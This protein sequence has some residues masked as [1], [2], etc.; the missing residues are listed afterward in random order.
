MNEIKSEYLEICPIDK[1]RAEIEEILEYKECKKDYYFLKNPFDI[2]L[3]SGECEKL[4]ESKKLCEVENKLK[5]FE[6]FFKEI[7]G[8]SPFSL[9]RYWAKRVLKGESFSIIA[10]TGFGKSTFGITFSLF[11][12]EVLKIKRVYYI[13]PTKILL[14]EIEDKFLR[15]SKNLKEV[16]ILLLKN[17]KIKKN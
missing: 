8:F 1:N 14:R 9:Q 6:L 4:K 3:K 5:A 2:L 13:V 10:P 15:Y 16:K 11:L 17:Q 7:T 12:V